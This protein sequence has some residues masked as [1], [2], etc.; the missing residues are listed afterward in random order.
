MTE[1]K[2]VKDVRLLFQQINE[3]SSDAV[4]LI[5]LAYKLDDSRKKSLRN[6]AKSIRRV[7]A[8]LDKALAKLWVSAKQ[9]PGRNTGLLSL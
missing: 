8:E 3:T 7:L 4:Q 6:K 1:P 2:E 5:C 9:K